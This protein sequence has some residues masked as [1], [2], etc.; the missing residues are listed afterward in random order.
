M[1]NKI[2]NVSNN[3]HQVINTVNS[4]VGNI[5]NAINKIKEEQSWLSQVNVET[6]FDDTD[7]TKAEVSFEWQVKELENNSEVLFNYNM[8]DNKKYIPIKAQSKGNGFFRVVVPVKVKPEPNWNVQITS[9]NMN[10]R[11]MSVTEEKKDAFEM[12]NRIEFN[13]YISVS[14]GEMVKSSEITSANIEDIGS[15][16]Y[17]YIE[18]RT[19]INK[20]NIDSL[21]VMSGKMYDTSTYL[22]E[23]YLKK[24]SNG[25]LVDEEKLEKENNIYGGEMPFRE[26]TVI[27]N[28]KS[29]KEKMDYNSLVL[30]VVYSDGSVFERQIYSK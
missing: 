8:G 27:F 28:T 18:V 1:D 6:I 2:S 26:D 19:N 16:Y 24:Y 7:K 14:S 20:N 29:S 21:S 17:G 30:K 25:K 4:Q 5:T 9:S 15:R 23:A 10:Q 13:Y 12:E 3:Q 11:E 22:R